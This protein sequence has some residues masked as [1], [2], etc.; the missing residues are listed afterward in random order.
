[1]ISKDYWKNF[2]K[3]HSFDEPS[4]FAQYVLPQLKGTL[5]DLGCGDGRD[6]HYFARHGIRAYGVDASNEDL[7][8]IKQD[9]N[10]FIKENESADNVY[11]RFFW[12]AID[13]ETQLAILNWTKKNIFIEARTTLDQPKD[14]FGKHDRNLVDVEQLIKDLT[15]TGFKIDHLNQGYGMSRYFEEDPHLVRAIAHRVV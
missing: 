13:H 4:Q 1:M 14:L 3:S 12:H 9:V 15:D 7:F 2:Y 5:V 6:L 8:I 10:A 11:T